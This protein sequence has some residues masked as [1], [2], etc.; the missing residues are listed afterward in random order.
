MFKKLADFINSAKRIKYH[1]SHKKIALKILKQIESEKGKLSKEV[2]RKCD[3]YAKSNLGHIKYSPWLY[4][5]SAMHGEFKEGWIPDNYYGAV[6]VPYIDGEFAKPSRLKPL[7][8]RLLNTAK[9]PDLL[10]FNN[11]LFIEPSSYN[12]ID[13]SQAYNVLFGANKTV[14]FKE[15]ESSQGKGIKYFKKENWRSD[16]IGH[17]NG[18]FQ[19]IINQH[20][21]FDAL[22]PHPGATIRMTTVID[23]FGKAAVRT[24]YLRLGRTSSGI[25][26]SYVKSSSAI[27]VA[28]DIKTGELFTTGYL[29]NWKSTEFHPDTG[30]YFK[31][32]IIPSFKKACLE[33]QELHENYPFV[34][35]IGWDISINSDCEVEVMEWNAE[36]NDIK[37]SEAMHGPC[38]TDLLERSLEFSSKA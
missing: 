28:I 2:I 14:I 26:T 38:F 7:S 29:A 27:R 5:Y 17:K 22:F 11:G 12:V 8:N 21:F 24:A 34:Q 33:V 15:N 9:L 3:E 31:G 35:C 37:F 30:K 20:P 10:Y 18:V 6:I 32:L 16:L 25:D 19:R 23:T 1:Y 4:V 13:E 36:H